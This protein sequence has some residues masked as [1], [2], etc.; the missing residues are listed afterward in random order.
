MLQIALKVNGRD[1]QVEVNPFD[2]L[3]KVFEK[4]SVSST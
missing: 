1:C 2:T 3:A 4:S